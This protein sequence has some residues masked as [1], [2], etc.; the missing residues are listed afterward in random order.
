MKKRLF[1]LA[2]ALLVVSTLCPSLP[3]SGEDDVLRPDFDRPVLHVLWVCLHHLVH[4]AACLEKYGTHQSVDISAGN[5]AHRHLL[6][7]TSR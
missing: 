1:I 3:V 6:A 4:H 5:Q 2:T 7:Q